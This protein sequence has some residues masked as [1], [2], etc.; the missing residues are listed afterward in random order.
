MGAWDGKVT[1][2][3]DLCLA[4]DFCA[5]CRQAA[6]LVHPRQRIFAHLAVFAHLGT[7]RCATWGS[8]LCFA[9]DFLAYSC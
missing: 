1:L 9:V 7:A 5:P 8:D 6:S 4:V 3:S 2:G